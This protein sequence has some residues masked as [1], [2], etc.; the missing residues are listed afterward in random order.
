MHKKKKN[1][2]K[3]HNFLLKCDFDDGDT[4][5]NNFNYSVFLYS[6]YNFLFI[7]CFIKWCAPVLFVYQLDKFCR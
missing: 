1:K 2:T 5:K 3:K 6:S 7:Q 4:V